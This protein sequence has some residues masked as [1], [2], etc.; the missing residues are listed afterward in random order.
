VVKEVEMKKSK[1]TY[2]TY[3]ANPLKIKAG[4]SRQT[5]KGAKMAKKKRSRPKTKT[6]TKIKYKYR[7]RK[8]PAPKARRAQGAIAA[9]L[10]GTA[11]TGISVFL[12]MFLSK[13]ATRALTKHIGATPSGG[14]D[15]PWTGRDHAI[16]IGAGLAL[17]I[18]A[19]VARIKW[20]QPNALAAG[21]VSMSVLKMI[22]DKAE[23]AGGKWS[24]YLGAQD[25]VPLFQGPSE[26]DLYA[27]PGATPAV[28]S[29]GEWLPAD[30]SHRLPEMSGVVEYNPSMGEVVEYSPRMGSTDTGEILN[31][32]RRAYGSGFVS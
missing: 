15:E 24:E 17:G 20:I 25:D 9:V 13:F 29:G 28:Y 2:R 4:E 11:K 5:N 7:A 27:E 18:I 31:Q 14:W 19:K 8:N 26:G 1:A 10:T 22:S 12:G 23:G 21:A 16:N 32:Y 30:D 3:A 6:K